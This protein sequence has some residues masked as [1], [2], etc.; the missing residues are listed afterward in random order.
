MRLCNE[1]VGGLSAGIAGTVLGYPLDLIKTRMQTATASTVNKS[2]LL[3]VV[4]DIIRRGEASYYC[5]YF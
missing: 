3:S 2:N 1:T 5:N 4:L